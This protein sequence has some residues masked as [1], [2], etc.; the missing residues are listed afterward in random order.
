MVGRQPL[1]LDILGPNPSSAARYHSAPCSV[2]RKGRVYRSRAPTGARAIDRYRIVP[3]NKMKFFYVYVLKSLKKNF[4]Y[5]GYTEN[6]KQRFGEHNSGQ[7][8]STK[9][10]LPFDLIHYEAYKNMTDAKRREKYL[11]TNRGKTTLKMM[12]KEYFGS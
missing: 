6:L 12:L 7:S 5:V 3:V 2:R 11:K 4:I 8:K 1:E 10:Y 9:P